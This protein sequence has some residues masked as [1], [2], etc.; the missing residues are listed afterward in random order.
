MDIIGTRITQEKNFAKG[1]MKI[2]IKTREGRQGLYEKR[3]EKKKAL[4]GQKGCGFFLR[5]TEDKPLPLDI[6]GAQ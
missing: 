1:K 6:I 5:L 2:I 4:V 3:F